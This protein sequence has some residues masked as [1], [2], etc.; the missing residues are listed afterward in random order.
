MANTRLVSGKEVLARVVRALGYKL[1]STYADDILE[2]IPEG[3]GMLNITRALDIKSTGDPDCVGELQVKNF[4]VELP[5]DFQALLAI[6]DEFG[7]RLPEGGDVTDLQGQSSIR[8]LGSEVGYRPNTFV[9]NPYLH[10]TNDG[11][12]TDEPGA[13]LP[14]FGQDIEQEQESNRRASYYKIVG[15]RIQT[16][17]EEGFIKLHY[18]ALPVCEEGYPLIPNNENFKQALEWHVLRRLIASGYE[19]RVFTYQYADEQFEKYAGRAMN[20][21]SYPSLDSASR[22]HRTLVRLIPPYR[23][24]DDFFIGSEQPEHL[25]K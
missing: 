25:R 22:L 24:Y 16:S 23:F 15:N 3:L 7:R 17:F 6:E 5:C 8:H 4:C 1:P 12:P 9:V 21:V 20:E 18:L 2:W 11:L 14:F 10:Q 19:H 13:A